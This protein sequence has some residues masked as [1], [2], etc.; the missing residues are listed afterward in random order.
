M[1]RYT[2]DATQSSEKG[3]GQTLVGEVL[4]EVKKRKVPRKRGRK[5]ERTK[6]RTGG[7]E[8]RKEA[9][10]TGKEGEEGTTGQ[11]P[12]DGD[13]WKEGVA[14]NGWYEKEDRKMIQEQARAKSRKETKGLSV[15]HGKEVHVDVQ[16]AHSTFFW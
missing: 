10:E 12:M 1:V 16:G 2:S 6:R 7:N 13:Q 11:K 3:K 14:R 15:K 9:A 4:D 5:E 8:E